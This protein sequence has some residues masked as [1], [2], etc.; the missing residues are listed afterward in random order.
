[1]TWAS[2]TLATAQ[3]ADPYPVVDVAGGVARLNDQTGKYMFY[4]GGP[5]VMAT[6][7]VVNATTAEIVPPV[8]APGVPVLPA[9][10]PLPPV[11]ATGTGTATGGGTAAPIPVPCDPAADCIGSTIPM[12]PIVVHLTTVEQSLTVVWAQ[13][14]TVWLLPA[15]T[16]H[17]AT[18][19]QYT[20][21]AVEDAFLDLA[22][23][24]PVDTLPVTTGPVTTGPVTTSPFTTAPPATVPGGGGSTPPDAS[25]APPPTGVEPGGPIV[26]APTTPAPVD[27]AS[28]A[29]LLVGLT[30]DEATKVAAQAGWTVRVSTLDGV[31]QQ[32][33]QDYS[34]TRVDVAVTSGTVSGV[35]SIG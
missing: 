16:F 17:D 14:G 18:D 32:L 19:A 25:T 21:V 28:A 26:T 9:P 35:D 34:P 15:Y 1:V 6:R 29:K 27:P 24:A 10:A 8:P 4:G 33:T 30:L 11:T 31:A 22:A 20:V 3:A 5:Q 7:G 13:D 23:P 12:E 2:G